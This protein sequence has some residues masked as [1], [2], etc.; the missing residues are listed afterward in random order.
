ME[1]GPNW[2]LW[3]VILTALGMLAGATVWIISAVNKKME[4]KIKQHEE[5]ANEKSKRVDD[6]IKDL[7]EDTE[8]MAHTLKQVRD[9]VMKNGAE[10]KIF[11]TKM[12]ALLLSDT[13][14]QLPILNQKLCNFI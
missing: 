6:D 8:D 2:E 9:M 1:N 5:V 10:Q 14:H 7:Q 13:L 12:E 11:Q 4:S 3:G